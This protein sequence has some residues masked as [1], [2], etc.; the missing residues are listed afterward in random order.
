MKVS[1]T[2]NMGTKAVSAV[3]LGVSI[4]CAPLVAAEHPATAAHAPSSNVAWTAD[5]VRFVAQGDKKRGGELNQSLFCASCHGNAGI[6]P[7]A[8]WPSLAGQ[9][10]QYTFKML[11]DFKDGKRHGSHSAEIMNSEAQLVSDQDMADLAQFYA[12]FDLPQLPEGVTFDAV[13]GAQSKAVISR[14]DGKRLVAP[15][16]SCH[17]SHGE[18]ES[19][20]SPALAGQ[21][22]EYL[23]KTLQ[24]YKSG[25]RGNDIYSRMRLIAKVLTDEEIVQMANYYAGLTSK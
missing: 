20:D 19:T 4:M 3:A 2:K 5:M 8:N 10:A 25:A 7:S 14:G 16:Q 21:S 1:H 17:G 15:C 9:R 12:S 6:A 11:K 22:P 24:E 13:L 18:G 23:I